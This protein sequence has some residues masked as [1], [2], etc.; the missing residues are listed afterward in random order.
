MRYVFF[1][2]T[3]A[4]VH[5]YR[6]AVDRLSQAGHDVLVLGRDYGCT[7]ALLTA[8][9]LP[10]RLYGSR[11]G[12]RFSLAREIPPQMARAAR[13]VRRFDPDLV[14][15][16]GAYATV[17][18]ALTRTPSCIVVDSEPDPVDHAISGR[19]ARSMLSPHAFG[20]DLGANHHT[21][22]G[23]KECAYLH[24]DV[25]EPDPSFRQA[26][27]LDP[28]ERFVVARFNGF[29][30]HHDVGESGLPPE[31]RRDLIRRLAEH[32]TVLVSDEGDHVDVGDLPA[33]E[34]SIAPARL[35]DA[36]AA[37]DLLV[38]DTQTVVTEAALL[39]TPAVRSN[40]FVGP[41]DMGNFQELAA[42]DLVR[43]I[44][45]PVEAVD[46]AVDLAAD[47]D[48][49]DR[50]TRRRDDYVDDLVNL[51]DLLVQVAEQ[52]GRVDGVDGIGLGATAAPPNPAD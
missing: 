48:A 22:R 23:F 30:A 27:G 47:P 34:F 40:S 16:M 12:G 37:A 20:K 41:D 10:F 24:P 46:T 21:F 3:P 14:F 38:A 5:L 7:T 26:L 29:D 6:H 4:Q 28:T 49:T 32:A 51:T 9:D 42:A 33:R 50:W 8:H 45:D 18:G 15:G 1:T 44:A 31:Q 36:L 19:L 39:G 52:R 13:L 25:F 17:T 35:H 2:N 43:N 11:D